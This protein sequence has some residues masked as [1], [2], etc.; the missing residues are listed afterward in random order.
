MSK[1]PA[2]EP[3]AVAGMVVPPGQRAQTELDVARLATQTRIGLP[4]AVLNGLRPGPTVWISAAIHGDELNGMAII[5]RLLDRLD[6]R[7]LS[8][9]LIAVPVVNVFG[10]IHQQRYLPDGRDLNRSFPGSA[11]GSLA[12]RL[13]HL[14]MARVVDPADFGIDLHTAGGHRTNLPQVRG[15]LTDPTTRAMAEA[16]GAPIMIQGESPGGSLRDAVAKR[17]KPIIVYEAGE[18]HRFNADAI[19]LGVKGVLAVLASQGMR[20]RGA[21]R[22]TPTTIETRRRT[23][24][25]ARAG[26]IA[27]LRVDLGRWVSKGESLGEIGD[28]FGA[29][30][31]TIIAPDDGLVIGMTNHPIVNQGDALV[32]LA[33]D[34]KTGGVA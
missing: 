21:R 32:H 24:V 26:G 17:G 12:A 19:D 10:F 5:D 14:F 29:A 11:R 25:R 20:S 16:F 22:R 15:D 31:S 8:G 3:F 1:R 2:A 23:W 9:R 7:R 13:A 27:R 28:V 33:T 34:V 6:P 4:V 18:P 30:Q